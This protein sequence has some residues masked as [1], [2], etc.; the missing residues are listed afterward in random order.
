M[1]P[2]ER[3]YRALLWLY[4]AEHRRAFGAVM[5]QHAR[6]M[7]RDARSAGPWRVAGLQIYLIGEGLLNALVEQM[8]AIMTTMKRLEPV[9]WWGVLLAVLPGLLL[10]LGRVGGGLPGTTTRILGAATV[11]LLVA[12]VAAAW[13]QSRQFP[14]WA[15]LPAGLLAWQ[16][17]FLVGMGLGENLLFP[18]R[19]ESAGMGLVLVQAALALVLWALLLRR[20]R[21]IPAAVWGLAAFMVLLYGVGGLVYWDGSGAARAPTDLGRWT[22]QA[23]S[24]PAEGLMLVGL[25]ALAA[26][27]HGVGALLFVLGGFGYMLM[28]SDYLSGYSLRNW[29]WMSLY[30][31]AM[32]LWY[33]VLAP[34]A[35]LRAR[36]AWGRALALL[37]PVVLF[38]AV[39]LA[40]PLLVG[41]GRSALPMGEVGISLTVVLSL[42]LGWL[43]YRALGEAP[44]PAARPAAEAE[45]LA[46][47]G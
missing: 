14:I 31:V 33:L 23:L 12:A 43:L 30:L 39:R 2:A 46:T 19:A 16:L 32:T 40:L 27:R 42:L 35:C 28:D 47:A 8:E 6:D 15:L 20:G 18:R 36:S 22:L 7:H 10:A 37:G 17:I 26:R 1:S 9:P 45:P 13:W 11:A 5:V 44:R 3:L 41:P 4:P 21:R 25:G 34:A 29:T 38:H 24:G